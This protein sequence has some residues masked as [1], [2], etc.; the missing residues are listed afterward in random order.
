MYTYIYIYI[1]L[2]YYYIIMYAEGNEPSRNLAIFV[3]RRETVRV[4]RYEYEP[5]RPPP[6]APASLF[7]FLQ[8]T[9]GGAGGLA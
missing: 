7:G 1:L 3:D 8:V 9:G 2:L 6:P 4:R 5:P